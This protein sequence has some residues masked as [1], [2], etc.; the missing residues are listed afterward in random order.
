MFSKVEDSKKAALALV[1]FWD[2]LEGQRTLTSEEMEEGVRAKSDYKKWAIMEET[3]WIQ[4]SR[5]I[6]LKEGDRNTS[7]STEWPTLTGEGTLITK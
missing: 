3:S 1:D 6:W 7:F 2:E 4:K 5:E